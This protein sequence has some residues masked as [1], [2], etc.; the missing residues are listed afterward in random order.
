[1][2]D[3]DILLG[4]FGLFGGRGEYTAKLKLFDIGPDGGEQE[5]DGEILTETDEISFECAARQKY[6]ILFE[7]PL[8][9][10]A[11]KWYVAWA[12]ISGPSSDCG[13]SGQSVV[14]TEDQVVFY[15]KSSKKSNNGT[16]VNA[17]QIPQLLYKVMSTGI[18]SSSRFSNR[19]ETNDLYEESICIV[20]KDFSLTVKTECFQSLL[21][22][23]RWSWKSFKSIVCD[24]SRTGSTEYSDSMGDNVIQ[25]KHL[26]YICCSALHLLNVYINEI[27]PNRHNPGKSITQMNDWLRLAECIYEV[28]TQLKHILSSPPEPPPRNHSFTGEV[29]A[30]VSQIMDE[31]HE[32]FLS[33]YHS[34]YPNGSLRWRALCDLLLNDD[35]R[36]SQK[37]CS[38]LL[39]A[40]LAA[41]CRPCV[42]LTQTFPI[43]NGLDVYNLQSPSELQSPISDLGISYENS[44]LNEK[45]QEKTDEEGCHSGTECSFRDIF[46]NL[47]KIIGQ[48]I[49]YSLQQ[50]SNTLD[51]DLESEIESDNS[52]TQLVENS[53]NLIITIMSELV[54]Q[55]TGIGFDSHVMSGQQLHLTPSRFSRISQNRTWNTGNGSPDA[56]CFSVDRAGISIAGITVYG[57]IGNEWHYELELL[58]YNGVAVHDDKSLSRDGQSH[59]WR[60]IELV[61][62][63]YSF[64]DKSSD[65]CE[66][67]F[68]RSV[69][70]APNV[71]YAIRLKN[72]GP[73]TNNGDAGLTHIRGADGTTF[74]F[75]D[76]SLS[77]NGTN[78]TRGQIPQILYYSTPQ[79]S[80]SD[81]KH[82][83][84]N[85]EIPAKMPSLSPKVLSH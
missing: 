44:V 4:G 39:S 71:K 65:V 79:S 40:M 34:F 18:E 41:L 23:L 11:N 66:M 12:R 46:N 77:F 24:M 52:Y 63:T 62:G 15:F 57:G 67:K 16:D 37:F 31:S 69:L 83:V 14:N 5:G 8:P 42:R 64:E 56:I 38:Y 21:K 75:S 47:L 49:R 22:L 30:F 1:M 20:S 82:F 2:A 78:H 72:H 59:S 80:K 85:E 29:N 54:A 48:P 26:T 10:Q 70:I 19:N 60:T 53:C 43:M 61:K 7:E 3:T 17:G 68:D 50:E 73:R 25:L 58:D 33:C 9:L 28:R 27:Y 81:S 84:I 55:V 13:S 36:L 74:T 51:M 32:T 45:I 76:C 35:N 6:P